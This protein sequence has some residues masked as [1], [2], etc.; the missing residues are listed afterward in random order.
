MDNNSCEI[1]VVDL[2]LFLM[3]VLVLV[4]IVFKPFFQARTYNKKHGTKYSATDF[5]FSSDVILDYQGEGK[6]NTLNLKG[7]CYDR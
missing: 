7:L 3:I 2:I 5:M 6:I 1:T 4:L